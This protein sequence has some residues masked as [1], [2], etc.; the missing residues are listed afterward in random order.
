M[1]S[2]L[3]DDLGFDS[4]L[5]LDLII[6]IEAEFNLRFSGGE[7]TLEALRSPQ[8][9]LDLIRACRRRDCGQSSREGD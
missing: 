7:L 4:G 8:R 9:I 6:A 2:D 5:L 3:F 1:Y